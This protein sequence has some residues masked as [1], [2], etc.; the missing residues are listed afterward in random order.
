[1]RYDLDDLRLFLHIVAEGSITAG[2]GRMHLSLPSASARVRS[3]EHH[4]GV[5]LL[6]RGRRGVRP[7]PAGTAL[8]RHARDV[9]DRTARLESAVASYARP[10]TAPLILLGG[11]SA[12]HRLVPRALVSFLRA[13]PDVDVEVSESRTPRTVRML[14]DGEADLGVVLDREA[15][16]CGL[17]T[18]P[19]GDDS[20]VVIGQCG[21]I[22]AGR[23][24]VTYSEVA[25]H[26]LV[27]LD[28]GSSLRRSIEKNLGPHAPAVRYR[29]TVAH[30]NTLV[31]LAAAGVGLAVVPRRAIAP[32]HPLDVCD[33]RDPWARRHHLL[34]WGTKARTS[35]TA[36]A[37][38][39]E[40]LRRAAM[41]EPDGGDGL[42][43]Q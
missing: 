3:L 17:T 43:A 32:H 37:A 25:E 9:L 4:A 6:I 40:H 31:S 5:D 26:P 27:G 29:T 7:T 19:L 24:E 20:L 28:A 11:G 1:M 36:A 21:G 41:S 14:A 13:H 34:A 10:P 8:A 33:L 22:L 18:E 15:R 12:M 2:A 38:L 30:L 16:D 39:A 23:T 42:P 35:S